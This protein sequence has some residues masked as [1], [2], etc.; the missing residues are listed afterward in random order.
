MKVFQ[1][2]LLAA[3]LMISV[4]GSA[5]ADNVMV[6]QA[7]RNGERYDCK[8][9]NDTFDAAA[10][11]LDAET[12]KALGLFTAALMGDKQAS[13]QVSTLSPQIMMS[14]PMVS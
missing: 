11:G 1:H 6:T 4:S 5:F 8:C 9:A 10:K 3:G 7:C 13:Q 2:L 12:T 14:L